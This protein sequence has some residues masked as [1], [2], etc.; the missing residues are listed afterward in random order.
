[1]KKALLILVFVLAVAICQAE[2]MYHYDSIASQS[3]CFTIIRDSD[4]YIFNTAAEPPEFQANPAWNVRGL[5]ATCNA[6]FPFQY[7]ITVPPIGAGSFHYIVF[8]STA[9]ALTASSTTVNGYE[10]SFD[11]TNE[12]TNYS[13]WQDVY[14]IKAITDQITIT[15]GLVESDTIKVNG[16]DVLTAD[17]IKD[18]IEAGDSLTGIKAQTDKLTFTGTDVQVTLDGEEVTTD[19]ASREASKA[20]VSALALQQTVLDVNDNVRGD[21]AALP[22]AA[23][24]ETQIFAHTGITEGGTWSLEKQFKIASAWMFGTTRLKSGYVNT[25]EVLDPD[26]GET[27]ILE[28]T[29]STATPYKVVTIRID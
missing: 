24:I 8:D 11:G 25:Y 19:S 3:Y 22:T 6:N 26:D 9:A 4:G 12:I 20:D 17:E 15:G 5:D 13:L 21:I 10:F 16:E 27:V 7:Y 23:E 18:T 14:A 28:Y 2:R 1:M 29:L